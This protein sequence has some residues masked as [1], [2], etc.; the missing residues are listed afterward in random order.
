MQRHVVEGEYGEENAEV[1]CSTMVSTPVEARKGVG[2]IPIRFGM[3][4]KM[5]SDSTCRVATGALAVPF[6][7]RVVAIVYVVRD[8]LPGRLPLSQFL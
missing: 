2:R 4:R 8:F 1:S 7:P 5:F 6:E 3:K